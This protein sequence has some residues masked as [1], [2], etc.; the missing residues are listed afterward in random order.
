MHVLVHA[1]SAGL[2]QAEH[3]PQMVVAGMDGAVLAT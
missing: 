2:G 1:L 3:K